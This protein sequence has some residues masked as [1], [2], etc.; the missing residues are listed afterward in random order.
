M[1]K[2]T[3]HDTQY[4]VLLLITVILHITITLLSHQVSDLE[5]QMAQ[6]HHQLDASAC[7]PEKQK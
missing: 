5:T 3:H 7:A 6:V 2:D 1:T 4:W